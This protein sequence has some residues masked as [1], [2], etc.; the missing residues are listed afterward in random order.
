MSNIQN[1]LPIAI[2]YTILA[3][4]G[5]GGFLLLMPFAPPQAAIFGF[6]GILLVGS[7]GYLT[8][9]VSTE[10]LFE[11]ADQAL[12]EEPSKYESVPVDDDV[13]DAYMNDEI[14]DEEFEREVETAVENEQ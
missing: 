13:M 11:K 14:T 9:K 10:I 6:V 5:I 2:Q 7:A 1:E 12:P 3:A 4:V 8:L